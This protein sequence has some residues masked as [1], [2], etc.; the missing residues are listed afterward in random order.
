MRIEVKVYPC[1]CE[2]ALVRDDQGRLKVYLK[3][4]PEKGKANDALLKMIAKEYGVK[5][6]GVK[7]ILGKTSRKKVLDIEGD[8]P[9]K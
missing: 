6:N 8:D 3:A 2:N 4:S 1:S 9:R 5:K 7:I